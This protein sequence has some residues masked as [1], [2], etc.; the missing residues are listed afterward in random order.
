VLGLA[1]VNIRLSPGLIVLLAFS[2]AML[3]ALAVTYS[4]KSVPTPVE[5]CEKKCLGINRS[6]R[7]VPE[8]PPAQTA[9]MRGRGPMRCE[10]Y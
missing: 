4:L 7:L 2:G 8:Y 9:G 3:F 1:L 5:A 6:G 10:C